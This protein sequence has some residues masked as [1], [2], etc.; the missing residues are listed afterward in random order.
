M[1]RGRAECV[2]L[3]NDFP[4]LE[5]IHKYLERNHI[6]HFNIVQCEALLN[7]LMKNHN[8]FVS[9]PSG[10]G[11][12]LI[13]VLACLQQIFTIGKKVVYLVP[14]KAIANEKYVDFGHAMAGEGI[15]IGISTG[16][17]TLDDEEIGECNFLILTYERFDGYLRQKAK[18]LSEVQVVVMDEIQIIND[19][20]RG[21]RVESAIARFR[22]KYPRRILSG[23]ALIASSNERFS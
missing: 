20:H 5:R 15:R 10:S 3:V 9:S 23:S 12:T 18:W 14:L 7:G 16:D 19:L 21:P 6:S 2:K 17:F 11:K 1:T 8:L 13:G 22:S 4:L